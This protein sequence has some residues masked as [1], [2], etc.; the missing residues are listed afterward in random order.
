MSKQVPT[1]KQI[2]GDGH[3]WLN[4]MDYKGIKEGLS[5]DSDKDMRAGLGKYGF[6][7]AAFAPALLYESRKKG[8]DMRAQAVTDAANQQQMAQFNSIQP[9]Q[10]NTQFQGQN[11]YLQGPY[12][13][14]AGQLG[15]QSAQAQPGQPPMPQQNPMMAGMMNRQPMGQQNNMQMQIEE[16]L[17]GGQLGGLL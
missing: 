2:F 12:N 9:S 15:G 11:P 1:G 16:L 10:N 5:G 17:R 14:A 3:K 7:A 4:P 6:H 8:S 13:Q